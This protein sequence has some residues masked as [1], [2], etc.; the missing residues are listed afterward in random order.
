MTVGEKR[1]GIWRVERWVLYAGS[2]RRV[3]GPENVI[4][5]EASER[6]SKGGS[7]RTTPDQNFIDASAI[8]DYFI[9]FRESQKVV[10]RS[11]TWVY[12]P[13]IKFANIHHIS[14]LSSTPFTPFL[15]SHPRFTHHPLSSS[16]P[17]QTNPTFPSILLPLSSPWAFSAFSTGGDLEHFPI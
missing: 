6:G 16:S 7:R 8:L 12:P 10:Q 3:N 13:L 11:S 4:Q 9:H 5:C 14:Y 1:R 2:Q 15:H 17:S